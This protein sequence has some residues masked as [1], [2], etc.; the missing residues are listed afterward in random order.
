MKKIGFIDY[1]LSE[2]HANNYP[3]WIAEK[4]R[5]R[6]G[7]EFRVTHAW[8]ERDVSPYDGV[9][10]D[11]WCERYG[12][13]RAP[14]IAAL[15]EAVDVIVILSPDNAENHLRYAEAVFPYGK[16]VYIDKTFAPDSATAAQIVALS[17]RYGTPFFSSS[18]LRFATELAP[19]RQADSGATSAVAIGPMNVEIYA[20]HLLEMLNTVMKNGASRVMALMNGKN[21]SAV[22]EYADGRRALY[23]QTEGEGASFIAAVER[24][25]ENRVLPIRSEMFLYF[26]EE[27]LEFFATGRRPVEEEETLEVMRMRT[28]LIQALATPGVWV[29]LT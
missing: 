24:E 10:T 14:S 7:E 1:F 17:H 25:G 27:L 8:A 18:A 23:C 13:E 12:V 3:D 20:V 4:S 29:D 9:S 11:A 15:C 22:F 5:E 28:A 2:W 26:I 21:R 16:P 19:Y 6:G